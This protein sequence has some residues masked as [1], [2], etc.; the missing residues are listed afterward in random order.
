M[1]KMETH[2]SYSLTKTI[3]G[4]KLKTEGVEQ[5]FDILMNWCEK[6]TIGT[7][8][9]I[10]LKLTVNEK[11]NVNLDFLDNEFLPKPVTST[12]LSNDGKYNILEWKVVISRLLTLFKFISTKLDFFETYDFRILIGIDFII[13]NEIG[14][15]LKGQ[16]LYNENQRSNFLVFIE[17]NRISVEPYFYL[18]FQKDDEE[19]N[20]FFNYLKD[21]FPFKINDKNL[22]IS[23]KNRKSKWG[24]TRTKLR[25]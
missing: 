23:I 21:N 6:Y 17:N 14:N 1:R 10:D 20:T 11:D 22:Y 9:S 25:R 19:F 2:I 5:G 18:P 3:P 8:S 12:I 24:F 13:L 15:A 16:N 7:F 4:P